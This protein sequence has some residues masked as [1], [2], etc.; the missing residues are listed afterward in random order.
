M[1]RR[2]P[3][4]FSW[5][6]CLLVTVLVVASLI[7]LGLISPR[8][9]VSQASGQ[10]SSGLPFTAAL[11]ISDA[12]TRDHLANHQDFMRMAGFP[13]LMRECRPG[14][15]ETYRLAYDRWFGSETLVLQYLTWSTRARAS[16]FK[17]E[18]PYPPRPQVLVEPRRP[19]ATDRVE[20]V[21]TEARAQSFRHG[22]GDDFAYPALPEEFARSFTTP[23]KLAAIRNQLDELFSSQPPVSNGDV[24]ADG[25]VIAIETC[26]NGR[27][28]FFHR[29]SPNPGD[30]KNI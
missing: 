23:E 22:R 8:S 25:N 29:W 27:Y 24:G 5:L 13:S 26:R 3:A 6:R 12:A 9:S 11:D 30:E 21:D 15:Q 10:T 1:R 28:A 18:I 4:R 20:A 2:K 17:L 19:A 7:G 16:E 14:S